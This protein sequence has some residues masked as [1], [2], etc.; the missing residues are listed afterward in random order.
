M[1]TDLA[2]A[3]LDQSRTYLRGDYLPRIERTL[4]TLSDEDL[5][6]RPNAASNSAGNLVLH[7][8]GNVRQWIVAGLGNAPDMREREAEFAAT[9]GFTSEEC[10][11]RLRAA[12]NDA[13]AVLEQMDTEALARRY[14]IQAHDV[15][16]LEAVYHVVEHFGMH[17]G[18]IL[19]IAKARTGEG[20]GL[21]AERPG[22]LAKLTWTP[23]PDGPTAM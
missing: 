3:F 13:C 11:V 8:A 17:T 16:G 6:W 18:Q 12:V 19:W 9:G 21:Y 5:W 15:T 23:T 10:L 2:Q 20:L 7:L 4:A 1:P 14:A 22:G